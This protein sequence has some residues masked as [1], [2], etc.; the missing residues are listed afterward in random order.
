MLK[1]LM[2]PKF[3]LF[4]AMLTF[5]ANTCF[6]QSVPVITA[7]FD[8]LAR[9]D[10]K[11]IAG[12]YA[13][14]A[15]VYSPNWEG[16]K[17]G[18]AGLTETYNRYFSSTPDLSYQVNHII[19]AGNEVIVQFTQ[20][21][22]LSN[23]ESGTP[24]YMKGKKYTLTCCAVFAVKYDKIVSETDYFDQVAFLRQVGFFDQH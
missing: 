11:A 20:S 21:G 23:P 7:H 19:N 3:L 5:I 10:V 9:H 14:T 18:P 24:T 12:G 16:A 17:V 2:K 1:I 15:K 13:D 6:S 4:I 8:A 22:T